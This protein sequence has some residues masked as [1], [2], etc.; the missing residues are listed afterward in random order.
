MTTVI[1]MIQLIIQNALGTY[2]FS[3]KKQVFFVW[4]GPV[5]IPFVQASTVLHGLGSD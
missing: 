5:I 3:D 2:W 1:D 4:L